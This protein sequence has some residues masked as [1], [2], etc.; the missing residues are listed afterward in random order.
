[1]S[2][3]YQLEHP[4]LEDEE[5]WV[6][7]RLGD[8]GIWD[9]TVTNLYTPDGRPVRSSR[10][11][12]LVNTP[13]D[14][15]VFKGYERNPKREQEIIQMVSGLVGPTINWRGTD[16]LLE[17][18][19]P[20]PEWST[21]DAYAK[22]GQRE[23]AIQSAGWLYA[24]LAGRGIIYGSEHCLDE[25]FVRVRDGALRMVDF[26]WSV[27]FKDV[28]KD[29]DFR[30][31]LVRLK[32]DLFRGKKYIETVEQQMDALS[33]DP[34]YSD[35]VARAR[36]NIG[37]TYAMADGLAALN[38]DL[39]TQPHP[40]YNWIEKPKQDIA[41][42]FVSNFLWNLYPSYSGLSFDRLRIPSCNRG[43]TF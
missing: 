14:A 11:P 1:M 13:N 39:R 38:V 41:T 6:N 2:I 33:N 20:S 21:L 31:R 34:Q 37:Y 15:F 7:S 30:K 3:E 43:T 18:Y 40:L 27:Q 19:F 22:A 29:H 28:K 35:L 25:C 5:G 26:G 8:A 42:I 32:G 10:Y 23:Y 36:S 9:A 4:I 12:L 17:E 16:R 24:Q